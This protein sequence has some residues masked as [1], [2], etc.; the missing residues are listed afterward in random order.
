MIS[1]ETMKGIVDYFEYKTS[2]KISQLDDIS[3]FSMRI[4]STEKA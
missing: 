2:V 1:G 4:S 3:A